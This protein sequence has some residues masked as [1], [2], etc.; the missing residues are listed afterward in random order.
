MRSS[1]RRE[2]PRA[3]MRRGNSCARRLSAEAA[4]AEHVDDRR[5]P[6]AASTRSAPVVSGDVELV[7]RRRVERPT[8]VRPYLRADAAVAQER[9]RPPRGRAAAE[10]EVE[11]PVARAAK[12][13]AAGSVEECRELGPSIALALRSDR[14]Q[15]LADVLGRDHSTTPSSASKPSL[16]VDTGVAV[17][18]D[19]V[20][21]DDS[22]TRHDEREPVRRAEGACGTS[23]SG[24]TRE[25]RELAV[26]RRSRR[27]GSPGAHPRA[28][29]EA[30]SPSRDR[31][32]RP[33]KTRQ[34]PP[35]AQEISE[36][37]A[38]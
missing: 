20:R 17:A 4:R 24:P 2:T 22:M 12:V 35:R 25:R 33:R 9:E 37:G 10:I 38:L 34:H 11:P 21:R 5:H 3:G 14:G 26:R 23:G 8:P 31:W 30:V 19:A 7:A 6:A 29:V 27:A 13:Q 15:L 32:P 36:S 16:H 28:R 18:P 1:R